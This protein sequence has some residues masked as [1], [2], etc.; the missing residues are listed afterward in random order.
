MEN[1]ASNVGNFTMQKKIIAKIFTFLCWIQIFLNTFNELMK[2][3]IKHSILYS[4]LKL[5]CSHSSFVTF[6]SL[7]QKLK[8]KAKKYKI[9]F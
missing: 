9:L 2:K 8:D 5:N 6:C 4:K 1:E 3:K 7:L